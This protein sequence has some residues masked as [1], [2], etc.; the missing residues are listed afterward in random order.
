MTG[1]FKGKAISQ[2]DKILIDGKEY[3]EAELKQILKDNA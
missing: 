1:F 3:T 2:I